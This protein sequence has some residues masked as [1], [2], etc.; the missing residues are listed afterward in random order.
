M[1]KRLISSIL[2]LCIIFSAIPI[3]VGAVSSDESSVLQ[4]LDVLGVLNGDQNGNLNLSSSVTRAEFTKM[5]IAA[6]IYKDTATATTGVSPFSDVR[7]SHWAS[8]Y[9]TVARDSSYIN[10]YLDGT[11]KPD[12]NVKLEEA[13]NMVLKLLGYQ[14]SDFKG[15]FPSSQMTLYKSLKLDE[16]IGASQGQYLTRRQCAY[17]IFN[18]LSANTKSGQ[19]YCKTLGFDIDS[20]G[21]IDFLSL[22]NNSIKGPIIVDGNSW[23]NDIGFTPT[24]VYKNERISSLSSITNYDVVYYLDK[25]K[26]VWAYSNKITGTYENALPNRTSPTSVVISGVTYDVGTSS[27]ALALSSVGG[28]SYGDTVTVLIGRD[29][30]VVGVALSSNIN[31]EIYGVVTSTSTKA[32]TDS[33][34]KTY[35]AT[36]VKLTATDGLSYEYPITSSNN[37]S[38]GNLVS[39]SFHSGQTDISRI[40]GSVSLYGKVSGNKLGRYTFANNV[41]ILDVYQSTGKNIS[42]SRLNGVTL[43]NSNISFCLLNGNGEVSKIILKDVTGDMYTY[44]V[45]TKANSIS[46]SMTTAGNYTYL[47]NGNEKNL[48]TDS[49]FNVGTGPFY[50][51]YE[52][53]KVKSMK[54]LANRVLFSSVSGSTAYSNNQQYTLSSYVQV[55]E[56]TSN[57]EYYLTDISRVNDISKYSLYGYYDKVE[58]QGGR[59]RIIVAYKK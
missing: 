3:S 49:A 15:V 55:Y 34:N 1:K 2:V 5:I 45:M 12:Y 57:N 16:N 47:I 37:F 6:S 30:S 56:L 58:N 50:M 11:F 7:S 40:S 25:T 51:L 10:G 48:I 22:I 23:Q 31:S 17:I 20:S 44:G 21:K 32:Y 33:N 8:G 29:N 18:T 35:S 19:P 59:I 28:Y 39:V 9:V 14:D 13:V 24:K 52:N 43:S 53:E 42:L 26:T 36:Y 46:S 4:T 41:E 38:A 27:A 54:N